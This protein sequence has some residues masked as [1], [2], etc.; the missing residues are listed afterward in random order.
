MDYVQSMQHLG[1]SLEASGEALNLFSMASGGL[2][3]MPSLAAVAGSPPLPMGYVRPVITVAHA[4]VFLVLI[5][6]LLAVGVV[7]GA[8]YLEAI[9]QMVR[10][11][12][13]QTRT[14]LWRLPWHLLNVLFLMGGLLLLG[15]GLS[16]PLLLGLALLGQVSAML[17]SLAIVTLWIGGLWIVLFLYFTLD[18]IFL[19]DVHVI[20]AVVNSVALVRHNFQVALNLIMLSV[21]ISVGMSY[22]WS[23]L[24]DSPGGLLV[25]IVGN[26]FVGT[27]LIAASMV[28]YRDRTRALV[29]GR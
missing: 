12:R 17:M 25:S 1:Q 6:I 28:F 18:A 13:W 29:L 26:A 20:Q 9:A 3:G 10:E 2:V 8:V 22:V 7:V 15:I 21:I 11:G 5:P 27:G 14:V 24:G 16:I 23:A 4:L 19:S